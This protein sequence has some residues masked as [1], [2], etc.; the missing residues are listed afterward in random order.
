MGVR[1]HLIEGRDGVV[2]VDA[3]APRK[4]E[5]ILRRLREIGRDDLR[6]IYITHDHLDHYGSAAAVKRST[7]AA[8]A[9]HEA[10][11][12]AMALGRTPLGSVRLWGHLVKA[13][14]LVAPEHLR[15]HPQ[16]LHAS[17][18]A[19]LRESIRRL[20]ALAPEWVYTGHGNRPMSRQGFARVKAR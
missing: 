2:L 20:Q 1:V 5:L 16:L 11:A 13:L 14:L 17:D 7:G 3:G 19:Q 9:V 8:I 18:W 12:E 4:E 15:P 6:L 10:D